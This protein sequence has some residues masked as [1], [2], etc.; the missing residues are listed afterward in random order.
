MSAAPWEDRA[1]SSAPRYLRFA[2]ALALVSGLGACGGEAA[3]G[4]PPRAVAPPRSAGAGASSIACPC[5][6]TPG[7]TNPAYCLDVGHGECCPHLDPGIVVG[8]LPP[9]DLPA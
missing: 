3:S 4:P 9:P 6:C 1:A 8:P 7:S 2:R 5:T